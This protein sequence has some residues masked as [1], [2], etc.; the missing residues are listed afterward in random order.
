MGGLNGQAAFVDTLG[1]RITQGFAL[2]FLFVPLTTL[3]L[4]EI[5]REK[6]SNATGVYTLIRQL[7]GSLGIAILTFYETRREDSA[8]ASLA[9]GITGANTAVANLMHGVTNTAPMMT[10][11]Y[12][13]V[14]A[15]ARAVA[16]NDVFRLC[17]IVFICSLPSILL[18][19]KPPKTKGPVAAVAE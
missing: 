10:N 18:L 12:M 15:N 13:M 5:S 7:G 11:V 16:Y 1:P 6:M 3:T 14:M 9:Q 8:Y 17:A 2:G 4:G 19:G